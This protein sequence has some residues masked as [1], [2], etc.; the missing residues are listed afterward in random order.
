MF[1]GIPPGEATSGVLSCQTEGERIA[2]ATVSVSLKDLYI[3]DCSLRVSVGSVL[4]SG[5]SGAE[6]FCPPLWSWVQPFPHRTQKELHLHPASIRLDFSHLCVQLSLFC[7]CHRSYIFTLGNFYLISLQRP[8][9]SHPWHS[10]IWES[11]EYSTGTTWVV[12]Y[13]HLNIVSYTEREGGLNK[14]FYSLPF[15]HLQEVARLL[16]TDVI[17]SKNSITSTNLAPPTMGKC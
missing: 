14:N 4:A 7:C 9:W 15:I 8:S 12:L 13:F 11:E 2:F 17:P 10:I 6:D 3:A 5:V 16:F 1:V